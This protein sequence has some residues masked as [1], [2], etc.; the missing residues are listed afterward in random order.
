LKHVLEFLLEL[1]RF[2]YILSNL[3]DKSARSSSPNTS[4]SSSGKDTRED[5]EKCLEDMLALVLEP[6]TRARL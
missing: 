2:S 4:K 1:I 5:K 6:D 3:L